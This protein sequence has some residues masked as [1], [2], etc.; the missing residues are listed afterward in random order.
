[1]ILFPNRYKRQK[2][3]G[4]AASPWAIKKANKGRARKSIMDRLAEEAKI[5]RSLDHPNIV[6]FKKFTKTPKGKNR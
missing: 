4:V 6:V 3:S 5:L 2:T 1:M